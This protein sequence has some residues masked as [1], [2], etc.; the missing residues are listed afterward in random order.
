MSDDSTD[1]APQRGTLTESVRD[2]GA[3]H[4]GAA[5]VGPDTAKDFSR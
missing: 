3:T 5:V 2:S 1:S 4:Q